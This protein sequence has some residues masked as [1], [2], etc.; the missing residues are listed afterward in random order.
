MYLLLA[1][2]WNSLF[3]P[4]SSSFHYHQYYYRY[5]LFPL[6]S[7]CLAVVHLVILLYVPGFFSLF[8]FSN[9]LLSFPAFERYCQHHSIE[10][11]RVGCRHFLPPHEP[12]GTLRPTS[13]IISAFFAS[14]YCLLLATAWPLFS[15]TARLQATACSPSVSKE[16]LL[17]FFWSW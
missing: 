13:S 1:N 14:I 10:P 4:F 2:P 11:Q 7:S 8:F 9:T 15:T 16:C 3:S 5:Q 17:R 12:P 6:L